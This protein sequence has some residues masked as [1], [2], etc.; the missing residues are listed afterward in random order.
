MPQAFFSY[1]HK[2]GKTVKEVVAYL[3]S[4]LVHTWIDEKKIPGGGSIIGQ[5]AAGISTSQ[6]FLPF[7][8][9]EYL[10]STWCLDEL[11]QAYALQQ[12]AKVTIIPILLESEE[13]LGKVVL[14][15]DK[16]H[17]LDSLLARFKWVEFDAYNPEKS[18]AGL[19]DSLW[20]NEAIR[21]EPVKV[22]TVGGLQLEVI[23]FKILRDRLPSDFLHHWDV[24]ISD[25][26]ADSKQDEK[27]LQFDLPVAFNGAGPNWLFTYLTIPLK[28]RRTVFVFNTQGKE[29][30]CV[31][32]LDDGNH[33]GKVL[34]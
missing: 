20:L 4:S 3:R 28:N 34:K 13:V 19:T 29:Y 33:P 18:R 8:S 17:F 24:N 26:V 7:L 23:S 9:R 22:E 11:E 30:V 16:R 5:I 21:F 14:P 31:Y 25:F 15:I 32:A 27:P 12:K 1:S 2:D 10:Q 6:Y